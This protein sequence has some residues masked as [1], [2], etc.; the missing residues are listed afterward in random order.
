MTEP[1]EAA[2]AGVF[3]ISALERESG[4][5][6]GTIHFYLRRGLLPAPQ[7]TA[8]SR[9]LYSDVHLAF[10]SKITELKGQGLSLAAIKAALSAE[11]DR[12]AGAGEDLAARESERVRRAILR[13]A[14]EEFA[15][16]GYDKTHVATIIRKLG[17]THQ[18]L[19]SHFSSKLELL[20]ES[21]RTFL[22]WNV[23]YN[24]A[25]LAAAAD[26]GERVLWRLFADYRANELASDVLLHIRS[27][28]GHSA[29]ERLR[30]AERAW[31][32]VIDIARGEFEA[33]RAP[34]GLPP[35]VPL[36]LLAH[37]MIGAH[38][39]AA[40]RASWDDTYSREDVLRTHLWLWLAVAAG[41]KGAV[42]I[43]L[44]VARYEDLIREVAARRP[45]MPPAPDD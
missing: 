28:K 9:S 12:S 41:M 1:E 34:L 39:N 3:N 7:K 45:E 21:F 36:E 42:D 13:V 35:P 24:E 31:Q 27:E 11:L 6:R 23:A 20:V 10:L 18:V 33:L 17:I 32:G 5:A 15:A 16:H 40:F 44:Q 29:A 2:I 14:T 22:H 8:A 37:S 43:D 30:L 38:H 25:R 19:Y 26:P 4:V